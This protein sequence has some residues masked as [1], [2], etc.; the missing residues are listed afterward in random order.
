M[1]PVLKTCANNLEDGN[2]I[3]GIFERNIKQSDYSV[4]T[5]Q[6]LNS[7]T[8]IITPN[9]KIEKCEVAFT[10]YDSNGNKIYSDTVEK[11][12]LTKGSGYAFTFDYGFV[13]ALSGSRVSYKITGKTKG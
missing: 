2:S 9:V 11:T 10:L 3:I 5:S 6:G 12:N 7:M 1:L 13:N 8:V 4:K